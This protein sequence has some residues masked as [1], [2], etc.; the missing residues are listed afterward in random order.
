MKK[1][2]IL[3]ISSMLHLNMQSVVWQ[4]KSG[5]IHSTKEVGQPIALNN[6]DSNVVYKDSLLEALTNKTGQLHNPG[7]H[8]PTGTISNFGPKVHPIIGTQIRKLQ[9]KINYESNKVNQHLQAGNLLK[10][11]EH[12]KKLKD[13]STQLHDITKSVNKDN[14]IVHILPVNEPGEMHILPYNENNNK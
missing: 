12:A 2:S 11:E 13:T 4:D 8:R 9:D 1:L 5:N 10:V 3:L 7:F 6:P 14:N